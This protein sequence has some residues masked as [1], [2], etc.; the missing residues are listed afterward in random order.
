MVPLLASLVHG[1][2]SMAVEQDLGTST[3]GDMNVEK[4]E[5]SADEEESSDK[6]GEDG[7]SEDEKVT[8]ED[9]QD[10]DEPDDDLQSLLA[11]I[12]PP[13]SFLQALDKDG[14]GK[15]SIEEFVNKN[16][17]DGAERK[18][19]TDT[20][21]LADLN[22][23]GFFDITEFKQVIKELHAVNSAEQNRL[24]ESMPEF[25]KSIIDGFTAQQEEETRSQFPKQ[26]D[27]PVEDDPDDESSE[28][29][30]DDVAESAEDDEE[31]GQ[32][33]VS[34]EGLPKDIKK[35]MQKMNSEGT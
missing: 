7:Q 30:E 1:A 23:D 13:E 4:E 32:E 28:A 9:L 31:I 2:T 14:D 34:A 11:D 16:G 19:A 22:S 6:E 25:E 10:A 20:F 24:E 12:D 15:I 33:K 18:H 8:K 5:D 21:K 27:D 29:A 17:T 26:P 3:K 35:A